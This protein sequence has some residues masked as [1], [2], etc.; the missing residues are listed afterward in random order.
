MR[1]FPL[2]LMFLPAVA[3]SQPYVFKSGAEQARLVEL[4]TSQ[5][6]SSCP[7][8]ERWLNN[9]KNDPDLW[10]KYVPV[11]FHVDYWDQLGW[12][13][14]Y[15]S[16]RYSTRQRNY[17][18][19]GN[20]H[21]VYTP[22]FVVNGTEWRGYYKNAD[23]PETG[24]ALAD[25]K[26]SFADQRIALSFSSERQSWMLPV[27]LN[28]AILGSDIV[29]DVKAGE[30]AR[31]ALPQDFV[32]LAHQKQVSND[33][34]WTLDTPKYQRPEVGRYAV[35]VWATNLVSRQVIQAT[36]GWLPKD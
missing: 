31:K 24:P 12:P 19:S 20:I 21:S 9:W 7:P 33:G 30:N 1:V 6:C 18:S 36:G 26:V 28:V 23:V 32:V 16:S 22:G 17:R 2:A 11:A 34:K 8:A 14:P 10:V 27:E 3:L 5:G 25:L 15:A 4:F 13:D 35:A 29:S